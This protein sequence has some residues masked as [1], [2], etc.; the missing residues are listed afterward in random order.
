METPIDL[1]LSRLNGDDVLSKLWKA[2]ADGVAG[3][4]YPV[5][6]LVAEALWRS[7]YKAVVVHGRPMLRVAPY[8]RYE[9]AWVEVET[10][11]G[12]YVLD[13]SNGLRAWLPVSLY[14]AVGRIDIAEDAPTYTAAEVW[15]KILAT[16]HYGPFHKP[17]DG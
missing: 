7:R 15:E 6:A 14:Y 11:D 2:D 9:H 13:L 1:V 16:G 12:P 8:D 5:A 17:L 4:C 3:N 10:E